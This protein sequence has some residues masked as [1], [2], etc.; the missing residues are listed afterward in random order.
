M[1]RWTR[2]CAA[3]TV[4]ALVTSAAAPVLAQPPGGGQGRQRGS[5]GGFGMMGG[6][7]GQVTVFSVLRSEAVQKEL[8]L[9]EDQKTQATKLGEELMSAMR[10]AFP[11][12]R[13]GEGERPSQEE[14]EK[15]MAEMRAKTDATMA[16]KKAALAGILSGEQMTRLEE[17]VL[18]ARGADALSDA[19]IQAK[20]MVS[21]DQK[22]KLASINRE[23]GEK[24]REALR[25]SFGQRGEGGRGGFD[26]EAMQAAAEK[27]AA[28]Q[29]EKSDALVAVL[30]PAQAE[31][32]DLMKGKDFAD[33]D[34][35]RRGGFGG[36]GPGGPGG[37][38]GRGQGGPGGRGRDGGD[39][40]QRPATDN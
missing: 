9:T 10:D 37:P 26:R 13:R 15:Q 6:G 8:A 24:E 29:K 27:R 14:R 22:S 35:V 19:D 34:S 2:I 28:M 23:F 33:I 39:R 12:G 16:E 7:G 11:M 25:G 36:R 5:F 38:G 31:Q 18:Q 20:L 40:P 32:F 4:A 17:I 3:A 1:Q 30:T 21:E